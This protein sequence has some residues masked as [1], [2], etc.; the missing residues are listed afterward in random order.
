MK[1]PSKKY[2]IIP[3]N[4]LHYPAE[5]VLGN[6][7]RASDSSIRSRNQHGFQSR[8]PSLSSWKLQTKP[9]GNDRVLRKMDTRIEMS[10][11]QDFDEWLQASDLL[12]DQNPNSPKTG[13]AQSRR[14]P[15]IIFRS[16][17]KAFFWLIM[18]SNFPPPQPH[19]YTFLFFFLLLK[20]GFFRQQL[21][22]F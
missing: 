9:W 14:G 3:K 7:P 15:H 19:H 20:K 6:T 21:S 12:P 13:T 5:R 11:T 4:S 16:W 2:I 22:R 18:F 8:T 1:S 10:I 17:P